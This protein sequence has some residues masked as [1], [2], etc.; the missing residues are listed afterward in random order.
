MFQSQSLSLTDVEIDD[1][2][3][4]YFDK[5]ISELKVRGIDQS[6]LLNI[7]LF[8][9]IGQKV[10]FIDYT[11][12]KTSKRLSIQTGVYVV[13]LK[14]VNGITNKKIIINRD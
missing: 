2:M 4:V 11:T 14:T 9:I 7:T 13:Q 10:K 5:T 6:E 3:S 8:N 12:N 1:N